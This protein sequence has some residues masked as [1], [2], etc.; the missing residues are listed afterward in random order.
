GLADPL[1]ISSEYGRPRLDVDFDP[2]RRRLVGLDR[3]PSRQ[4]A[5]RAARAAYRG[6]AFRT[7]FLASGLGGR[8]AR[9]YRRVEP[10]ARA[11]RQDPLGPVGRRDIARGAARSPRRFYGPFR[12]RR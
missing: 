7:L 9:P 2:R 1:R 11:A 10:C 6:G 3:L 12:L 4:S 8:A 5:D